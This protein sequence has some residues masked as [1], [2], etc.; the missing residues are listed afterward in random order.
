V[1]GG[2]HNPNLGTRNSAAEA[3]SEVEAS[4]SEAKA[5]NFRSQKPRGLRS[6][7][8]FHG[9]LLGLMPNVTARPPFRR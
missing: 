5:L 1:K 9:N 8:G 4:T 7:A 6:D 3:R 2:R